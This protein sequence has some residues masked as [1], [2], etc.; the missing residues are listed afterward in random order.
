MHWTGAQSGKD[1]AQ[2][3]GSDT[4][5][6]IRTIKKN[7]DRDSYLKSSVEKELVYL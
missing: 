1:G 6:N 3:M 5:L 2:N 7:D 4:G